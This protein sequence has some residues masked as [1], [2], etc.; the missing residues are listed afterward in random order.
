MERQRGKLP[1]IKARSGRE[2]N[3]PIPKHMSG[4]EEN[5]PISK[6]RSPGATENEAHQ[7]RWH[8]GGKKSTDPNYATRW[9]RSPEICVA[10]ERQVLKFTTAAA[11]GR[12]TQ[13]TQWKSQ[14]WQRGKLPDIKAN[15]PTAWPADHVMNWRLGRE[16]YEA[17]EWQKYSSRWPRLRPK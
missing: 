7:Q 12:P 13:I 4:R 10:Q 15:S 3:C 2:E 8:G 16:P 11:G 5:C 14:G 9:R 17:Q 6:H 1:D